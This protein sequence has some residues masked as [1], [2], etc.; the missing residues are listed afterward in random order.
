[1]PYDYITSNRQA[2]QYIIK[3]V[4]LFFK[5]EKTRAYIERTEQTPDI[6]WIY[7]HP[8]AIVAPSNDHQRTKEIKR[9]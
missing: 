9:K 2:G 4:E 3:G 6:K 5:K 7:R 8:A 1:M